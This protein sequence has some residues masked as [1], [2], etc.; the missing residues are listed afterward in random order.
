MVIF[1]FSQVFFRRTTL[2]LLLASCTSPV[3]DALLSLNNI[4]ALNL[5]FESQSLESIPRLPQRLLRL[6]PDASFTM[7]WLASLAGF[8]A[9]LFLVLSPI[10][11]YSDQALSMHRKKSSAGFS[12]D[13]PLIMLVASFFRYGEALPRDSVLRRRVPMLAPLCVNH[14]LG[15]T[16]YSTTPGPDSISRYSYNLSLW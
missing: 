12:L 5:P 9:P 15:L 3:I 2:T 4:R 10:L 13:I 14:S 16:G 11:S 8:C 7:Q 1:A 6:S